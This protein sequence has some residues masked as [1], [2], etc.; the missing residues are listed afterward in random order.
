M[1]K[2]ERILLVAITRLG[3]MLQAS[4]TIAGLKSRY[5]GATVTVAIEK[6]FAR[7]CDGIPGIDEIYEIDLTMVSQAIHRGGEGVVD[8]FRYIDKVVTELR[9]RD[10]DFCLNMSSS[11][12]TALLLRMLNIEDM[13]GWVSDEEGN[14]LILDPWAMLFSAFVYHSNRDYNSINIVDIFRCSSGVDEHPLSL[15]FNVPSGDTGF[16]ERFLK[17]NQVTGSGPVIA[18]QAGA[19]QEKR[20]WS[21]PRFAYLARRLVEDLDARVIFTGTDNE[22]RIIQSIMANYS[23]SNVVSAAGRTNLTQLGGLLKDCALLITGD[24]GTMHLSIAVGTPVVALFLA[25]A[26]CFETGPYS[27]G[28]IV[29]QPQISCNPCNPN[30]P[31]SRPDCH[32]QIPPEL[33]FEMAKKRIALT[34]EELLHADLRSEF[35][36]PSQVAVFVTTF[37]QDRFL[38][39]QQRNGLSGKGGFPAPYYEAPRLA[40]R[41][42]WKNDFSQI[43]LRENLNE[44]LFGNADYVLQLQDALLRV[45]SFSEASREHLTTLIRLIDD[46]NSPPHLLGETTIA[47]SNLAREIELTALGNGVIGALVRMFV[48]EKENQRGNDPRTLTTETLEIHRRFESRCDRFWRLYVYYHN[49]LLESSPRPANR[50]YQEEQRI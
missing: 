9:S 23:H 38:D 11:A 33:V 44:E 37:D 48:M 16:L 3:D 5:P 29:L 17:D 1:A 26:L 27:A 43:P 50:F 30:L 19:S 31:C 7:V 8:A 2:V 28:N 49:R 25:S 42:L 24:T 18:I 12:Y 22:Q 13:R 21:P 32:D 39:F 6:N 20:Q 45:V 4:P 36:D 14:R 47:L 15:Q 40:Y 34:T 41:A 35:A 46:P 10:F